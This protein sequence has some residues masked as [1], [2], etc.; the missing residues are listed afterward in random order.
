MRVLITGAGGFAGRHLTRHL[1]EAGDQPIL[2]DHIPGEYLGDEQ[3]GSTNTAP[4]VRLPIRELDICDAAACAAL[5]AQEK[6]RVVYH[7]AGISFAPA[8]DAQFA[9]ALNVNVAGVDN[10]CRALLNHT[11]ESTFLLVS[12]SEVYGLSGELLPITEESNVAPANSYGLTKHFAEQ[13][14]ERYRRRSNLKGVIVRAFNHIGPGQRVDFVVPSFAWQIAQIVRGERSPI[15]SVGNL[16][17]RRDFTDVRDIVR[18]YRLA[19]QF[20]AGVFNLCSGRAVSIQFILDTLIAMAGREISI[21]QDPAR[22]RAA[23][24]PE[25]YG[26]NQLAA[27]Q[28]GWQPEISIEQSLREVLDLFIKA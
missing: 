25:I 1:L 5:I 18:G 15:I 4:F 12:S 9:N 22:M 14:V 13:V 23:E 17:A 10:L 28:L 26:S 7:L 19:A 6:P 3:S 11:P 21:S 20:G 8:A 27:R 24:I 2:T 16:E